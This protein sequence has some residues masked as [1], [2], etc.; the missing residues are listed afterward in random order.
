MTTPRE[1]QTATLLPNGQVLVAG[2]N[3]NCV[4]GSCPI[5]SSAELYNPAPGTWTQD[6]QASPSAQR[7]FSTALLNTGKV[8]I[9]GGENGTYP[10]K[11]TVTET[12][13]LFDPATHT[14]TS[15]GSMTIRA[16]SIR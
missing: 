8:L 7:D 5:L 16:P 1:N 12:A 4:N 14:S 11:T 10:A 3:G 9:S 6:G 2:G 15:T 13:T